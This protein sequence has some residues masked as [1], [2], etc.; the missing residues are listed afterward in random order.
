MH[1]CSTNLSSLTRVA[2]TEQVSLLHLLGVLQAHDCIADVRGLGLMIGIEFRDDAR[3]QLPASAVAKWVQSQMRDRNILLSLDGPNNN[4]I[5]IKPPMVF[6]LNDVAQLSAELDLVSPYSGAELAC[7][8]F[9]VMRQLEDWFGV[10][11]WLM[12]CYLQFDY[13]SGLE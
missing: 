10:N 1:G 13:F 4:V 12:L 9:F 6:S 11:F 7:A 5:K 8:V 3:S 2:A